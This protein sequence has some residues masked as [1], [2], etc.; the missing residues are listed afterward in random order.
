MSF[1]LSAN[2]RYPVKEHA[3][4]LSHLLRSISVLCSSDLRVLHLAKCTSH[5][6]FG[7]NSLAW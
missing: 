2:I 6:A 1:H 5:T 3:I 4:S 7:D